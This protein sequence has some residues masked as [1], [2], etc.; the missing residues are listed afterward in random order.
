MA[1]AFDIRDNS[2]II[3]GIEA[4]IAPSP[5]AGIANIQ[6]AN[7]T[8]VPGEASVG[9]A[10]ELVMKAP[11]YTGVTVTSNGVSN[12]FII[13]KADAS[14]LES[15]QAVFFTNIGISGVSGT[16]IYYTS[17]VSL[18]S[19]NT[20]FSL[21]TQYTA[22]GG[23]GISTGTSGT[24][25]MYVVPLTLGPRGSIN[26]NYQVESPN[27]DFIATPTHWLADSNGLV[28]SDLVKTGTTNSWTYT[29]NVG[30]IANFGGTTDTSAR[31]QGFVY[32]QTTPS[33]AGNGFDGWLFLWRQSQIDYLKVIQGSSNIAST[34]LSWQYAWKT[35]LVAGSSYYNLSGDYFSHEA[36]ITPGNYVA[37][38]DGWTMGLFYQ[39]SFS[40]AFNPTNG[41]TYSYFAGA[42]GS[43]SGYS[44]L[45][46]DDIAQCCAY[47]G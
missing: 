11:T 12:D 34:S 13:P 39:E 20:E 46:A 43:N 4:G 15:G 16:R 40:T 35:G 32:L 10:T 2:L 42:T 44:I 26:K 7:I 37:F 41:S 29:G 25:T 27:F 31:G 28:W 33:T 21:T 24:M 22:S 45:P 36:V 14:A 6:N 1:Y 18:G 23:T 8:T 5:Y 17:S 19:T 3:S 47:T 38:C 30:N 9:F